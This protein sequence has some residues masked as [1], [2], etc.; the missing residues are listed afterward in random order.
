MSG[1][2]VNQACFSGV[3]L[4]GLGAESFA[5]KFLNP[6]VGDVVVLV[7]EYPRFDASS[8]STVFRRKTMD[9]NQESRAIRREAASDGRVVGSEIG[10]D[11]P[12]SFVGPKIGV[13]RHEPLVGVVQERGG[14]VGIPVEV[15]H[16]SRHGAKNGGASGLGR[17]R[18]GEPGRP[19]V[20][21]PVHRQEFVGAGVALQVGRDLR[22]G[23]FAGV[24][25]PAGRDCSVLSVSRLVHAEGITTPT[26]WWLYFA[27]AST[28]DEL[29]H[30]GQ[31]DSAAAA[32]AKQGGEPVDTLQPAVQA[33]AVLAKR[34]PTLPFSLLAEMSAAS[35]AL[36]RAPMIGLESLDVS[37][38]RWEPL[39]GCVA[40]LL[41][42]PWRL[43]VARSNTPADGDS[44]SLTDLSVDP[45]YRKG[46]IVGTVANPPLAAPP[47]P[48]HS[49]AIAVAEA[50]RLGAKVDGNPPVRRVTLL[51]VGG[52]ARLAIHTERRNG[53]WWAISANEAQSAATVIAQCRTPKVLP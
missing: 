38:P 5:A 4:V 31:L 47:G 53:E 43:V 8:L 20:G 12:G 19:Q 17:E 45:P 14:I 50:A 44:I 37:F 30:A 27:C 40:G 1:R 13:E 41:T 32:W 3:G 49:S 52:S 7:E 15:D 48:D 22:R 34:T 6:A 24:E 2:A 36:D 16:Q 26:M 11:P 9:R 46:R 51:A 10:I 39:L 29:L 28:P 33:L 18:L 25:H 42:T 21:T 35:A 23:V